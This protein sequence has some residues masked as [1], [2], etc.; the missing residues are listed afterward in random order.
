[1]CWDP[2]SVVGEGVPGFLAHTG[3]PQARKQPGLQASRPSPMLRA[4]STAT[5]PANRGTTVAAGRT[6]G[7][8]SRDRRPPLPPQRRGPSPAGVAGSWEPWQGIP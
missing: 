1:M 4:A 2:G 7:C 5:A 8:E 3:P 6:R